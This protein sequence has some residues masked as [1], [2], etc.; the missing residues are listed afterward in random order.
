MYVYYMYIYMYIYIYKYISMYKDKC[1][2]IYKER[3]G[4]TSGEPQH[5]AS[6]SSVAVACTTPFFANSAHWKDGSG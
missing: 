1:I 5:R 3:G 2:Y 6:I 4:G